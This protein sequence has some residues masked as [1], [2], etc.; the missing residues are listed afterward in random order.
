MNTLLELCLIPCI[1]LLICT[2]K[3]MVRKENEL[4]KDSYLMLVVSF[5][6]I[7]VLICIENKILEL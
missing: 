1:V 3:D 7:L 5:G 2:S 4:T 6:L